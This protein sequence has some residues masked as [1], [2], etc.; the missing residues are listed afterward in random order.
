MVCRSTWTRE[1]RQRQARGRKYGV[2]WVFVVFDHDGY[3]DSS[4]WLHLREGAFYNP[5]T[6]KA[7]AWKLSA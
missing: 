7:G 3:D 6:A 4:M 5:K 1:A 2:R